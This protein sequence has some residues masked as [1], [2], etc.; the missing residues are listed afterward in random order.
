MALYALTGGFWEEL[1]L[2]FGGGGGGGGD[3]SGVKVICH[4]GEIHSLYKA[5]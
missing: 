4:F 3:D 1:D 5:I 2:F